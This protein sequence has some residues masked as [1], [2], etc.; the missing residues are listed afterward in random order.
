MGGIL[1]TGTDTMPAKI[2][3]SACLMGYPVRY[4]GTEKLLQHP[5]KEAWLRPDQAVIFCPELAA[6]FA[7]PRP[8]AEIAP[9]PLG[10][11]VLNAEARVMESSGAD[12]SQRYLLAAHLALQMA[13]QHGCRYALLTDGSPSCGSNFI[14][15]GSFSGKTID[16]VGVT[17]ELLRQ[18][19]IQVF[20][21]RQPE[22]LIAQ[23]AI[24]GYSR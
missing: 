20:S 13:Q 3:I 17:T 5:T 16:G 23:L 14:Y 10:Y 7:T 4:N 15:D 19:G 1:L 8:A 6:G 24:A 21:D 22:L 9:S 11:S 18:H 2:L 12:V